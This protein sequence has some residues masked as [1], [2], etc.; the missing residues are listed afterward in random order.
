MDCVCGGIK[1]GR[2]LPQCRGRRLACGD[3]RR[4][5]FALDASVRRAIGCRRVEVCVHERAPDRGNRGP[6]RERRFFGLLCSGLDV[7]FRDQRA[8]ISQVRGGRQAFLK[9]DP[10]VQ[11]PVERLLLL[12]HRLPFLDVGVGAG[13]EGGRQSGC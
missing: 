3:E 11:Q 4:T 13:G 5:P 12:P 10:R 2:G 1:G 6:E 7:L 9:L 8:G